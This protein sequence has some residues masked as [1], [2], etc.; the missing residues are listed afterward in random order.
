MKKVRE[1]SKR[2]K[3]IVGT[4]LS[5]LILAIGYGTYQYI[6]LQNTKKVFEA[7]QKERME[8]L[9]R[10]QEEQDQAKEGVATIFHEDR[11]NFLLMG[12]DKDESRIDKWRLFR[13]DA[14]VMVSL[15]LKTDG[16][17]MI[18]FPRDALVWIAHRPGKD[19]INAAFY[20]GH[21]LGG[22]KTAEEKEAMGY[23]Y[24]VDTVSEFL[25]NI[26]IDNYVAMDMD[27]FERLIDD[28]GGVD[29]YVERD[30]YDHAHG[31]VLYAKE[32][33]QVLD[34]Y[35]FLAYIRDRGTDV[36]Q[37]EDRA[38]RTQKAFQVLY[39]QLKDQNMLSMLPKLLDNYRENVDTNMTLREM[40]AL[41]LYAQKMDMDS[42]GKH[43]IKG[44]YEYREE[45]IY[46]IPDEQARID[47]VK[48][49]FGYDFTPQR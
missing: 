15:D 2:K 34:G 44:D 23:Q 42:M 47:L 8:E 35:Q 16:V 1:W 3:I 48:K 39:K 19:K 9:Q 46:F 32:G 29:M 5:M 31:G 43:V 4:V 36:T 38:Q 11:I 13:P 21:D 18:S 33:Q 37:D 12:F 26:Y 30:G 14:L 24:V 25:G 41:A 22:G 20:Y 40:S 10:Q 49:V 7:Q 17:D 27:G 28:M 45:Q 6:Q